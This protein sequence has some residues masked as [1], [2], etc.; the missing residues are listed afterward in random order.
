MKKR[1]K[2]RVSDEPNISSTSSIAAGWSTTWN[3]LLAPKSRYAISALSSLDP[4]L[5]AIYEHEMRNA[6]SESDARRSRLTGAG[7]A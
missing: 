7:V 3:K 1:I 5:G 6:E 2:R 4:N